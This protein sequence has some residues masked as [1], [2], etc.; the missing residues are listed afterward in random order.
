MKPFKINHVA[1]IS[2][3]YQNKVAAKDRPKISNAEDA[4]KLLHAI[5]DKDKIEMQE[6][7]YMLLLTNANRVL[8]RVHLSSGGTTGT[9]VD[10][11]YIV[12]SIAKANASAIILAHNHPSGTLKPSKADIDLTLK[13]RDICNVLGTPVLDH[14][15]ITPHDGYFS[16]AQ[17][18]II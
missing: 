14:V 9:L 15:I 2:L 18:E 5:W 3:S 11:K 7:F 10:L 1:E 6:Q 17:H 8:G 12:V 13:I 16:F 4:Y